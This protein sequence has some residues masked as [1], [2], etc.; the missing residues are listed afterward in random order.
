MDLYGQGPELLIQ[1]LK[2]FPTTMWTY[3]PSA[4]SWSIHEVIIHLADSEANSYV[5]CRC[6]I[7]EPGKTIMAYDQDAW[8]IK[9]DYHTTSTVEAIE[10]FKVLRKASYNRIKNIADESTWNNT[11][12]HPENGLMTMDNWLTEYASHV[13]IHIVQMK[14]VYE[15][16]KE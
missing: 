10:I 1:A 2:E 11:I 4:N 5:R 13:P 3:K 9:L 6:L 7:A 8:A 16:W 15:A 14:R 12:H